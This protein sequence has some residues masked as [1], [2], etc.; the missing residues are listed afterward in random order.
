MSAAGDGGRGGAAELVFGG[1]VNW[2]DGTA[3]GVV[4]G[5]AVAVSVW[6]RGGR[7]VDIPGVGSSN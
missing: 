1:R 5:N 4:S 2:I 6:V 7:P 3:D